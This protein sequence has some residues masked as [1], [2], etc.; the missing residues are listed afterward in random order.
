MRIHHVTVPAHDPAR[1][2]DVL[3]EMLR[4]ARHPAPPP[5]GTL[6]VYAGDTDG[7][8]IEV[9]PAGFARR[10]GDPICSCATSRCPRTGPTTPS[11]PATPRHRARAGDLR[12]RRLAGRARPQR[13]AQAGFSLVRGLIENHTPIEIGDREMRVEYERFFAEIIRHASR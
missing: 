10:W 12:P 6:L 2:A 13:P 3:A 5:D 1:V 4:R 7:T 11:S 8:A 9:W